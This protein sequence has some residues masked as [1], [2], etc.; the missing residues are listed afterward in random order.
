MSVEDKG[1]TSISLTASQGNPALR[2][3]SVIKI[4][5]G[6]EVCLCLALI[7]LFCEIRSPRSMCFLYL[8]DPRYAALEW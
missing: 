6:K 8:I 4:G 5:N 2:H 1:V 7:V 3:N